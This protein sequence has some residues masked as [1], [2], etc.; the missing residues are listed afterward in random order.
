MRYSSDIVPGL[1]F[2]PDPNEYSGELTTAGDIIYDPLFR[3]RERIFRY[4]H[5]FFFLKTVRGTDVENDLCESI[6]NAVVV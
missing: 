1:R 5:F 6:V 4:F 2:T 3:F